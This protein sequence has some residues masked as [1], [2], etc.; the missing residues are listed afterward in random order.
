[1]VSH[2]GLAKSQPT[3]DGGGTEIH[4]ATRLAHDHEKKG[5]E[6]KSRTGIISELAVRQEV[7]EKRL[8]GTTRNTTQL[9][10][11]RLKHPRRFCMT[12]Y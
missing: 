10:N 2:A 5:G 11:P 8:K 6:R 12:T 4:G 9:A 1:M 3:T 7:R